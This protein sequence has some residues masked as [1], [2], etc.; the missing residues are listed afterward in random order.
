MLYTDAREHIYQ[1]NLTTNQQTILLDNV[2]GPSGTRGLAYDS[3]NNWIYFSGVQLIRSRPDGTELQNI[4]RHLNLSDPNPGFQIVLDSYVN[5][6]NPRVYLAF[7]GDLYMANADGSK[8]Q[9]IY[10]S[11]TEINYTGPYGV[12]IGIDPFDNKRYIYWCRGRRSKEAYLERSVLNDDGGL[13]TIQSIWSDI[14]SVEAT[15]LYALALVPWK[16]PSV[17]GGIAISSPSIN[18]ISFCLFSLL[19]LPCCNRAFSFVI[20]S[21]FLMYM[22]V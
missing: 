18:I 2:G 16:F 4:T 13:T 11:P 15:W 21:F 19:L 20:L 1:V 10:S 14:S 9:L 6:K 5:P 12:A 8:E 3:I 7:N 22:S 17:N